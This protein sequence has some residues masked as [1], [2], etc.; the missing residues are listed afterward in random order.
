MINAA[1]GKGLKTTAE[2][3][4]QDPEHNSAKAKRTIKLKH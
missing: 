2:A 1:G 4:A 3:S